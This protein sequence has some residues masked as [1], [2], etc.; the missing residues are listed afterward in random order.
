MKITKI[1]TIAYG[2]PVKGFADAYTSF[3]RSDAILVKIY[4]DEGY[5]GIGEACAW[6]PEFYG[7]TRES[8]ESTIL[9]YAAP[10]IIGEDPFNIGHIMRIL[11][12]N[13]A[14]ITC[15]KEGIDL[16]LH[17]LLGKILNVPVYK[18]LGGKF[19]DK[20]EIGS[21]IGIKSPQ[22]MADNALRVLEEGIRVIKIKGSDNMRLDVDRIKTVRAAVGDDVELRLDPNAA[23]DTIGSIRVMRAVEDCNLQLLEQPIPNWDLKGM[24]HIRSKIGVPVMADESIWTP[25]DAVKIHDYGAAD[26]LNLKI[27]KTCGLYLGKKVEAVAEALGLPCIAGTELEP[28]ISAVAKI[29]LAAS[30]KIHPIASEFTELTQVDGSILKQPLKVVDG[31]LEV[32]EGPGFGVEIDEDALEK[33]RIK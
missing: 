4:T 20:I 12:L 13:L 19:R 17:D 33:Y 27:A 6:E 29:H 30:M 16:A 15:V 31:C 7:E 3:T 21:E 22:E 28:G 8:I 2:I 26:L 11:D 24:A 9:N 25:Q 14:R 23:W 5:V 32:P 18:L 1:E 10:K